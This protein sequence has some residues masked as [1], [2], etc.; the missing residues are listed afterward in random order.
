MNGADVDVTGLSAVDL[1]RAVVSPSC[2]HWLISRH[3]RG[4]LTR[5]STPAT[6][7][8]A[9]ASATGVSSVVLSSTAYTEV[10]IVPT[11]RCPPADQPCGDVV[12]RAGEIHR[13][14]WY[15]RNSSARLQRS[16]GIRIP[17][18][19]CSPEVVKI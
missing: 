15:E 14:P 4:E 11:R 10:T 8:V 19:I 7:L 3:R 2:H 17:S 1:R 18:L 12:G 5:G 9:V 13:H 16:A 6:A